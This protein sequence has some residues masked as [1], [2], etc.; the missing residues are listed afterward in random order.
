MP[1]LQ[2]VRDKLM[3]I[4]FLDADNC[5]MDARANLKTYVSPVILE[6]IRS[7]PDYR[8]FTLLTYRRAVD[9]PALYAR[10]ITFNQRAL[11]RCQATAQYS[12]QPLRDACKFHN[13]PE[14]EN[15]KNEYWCLNQLAKHIEEGTKVPNFGISTR[16]DLIAGREFHQSYREFTH[17]FEELLSHYE[18]TQIKT[19]SVGDLLAQEAKFENKHKTLRLSGEPTSKKKMKMIELTQMDFDIKGV[20]NLIAATSYQIDRKPDPKYITKARQ[21][22]Q[23]ITAL[24]QAHP[25]EPFTIDVIDDSMTVIMNTLY[26]LRNGCYSLLPSNVKINYYHSD[27]FDQSEPRLMGSVSTMPYANNSSALFWKPVPKQTNAVLDEIPDILPL[28][29]FR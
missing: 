18:K 13:E 23:T 17:R 15:I 22:I 4:L 29:S 8:Y 6:Y 3:R 14:I 11:N 26:D 2:P 9:Y 1:K 28:R 20:E 25:D 12:E 19:I 10:H 27:A 24:R 7:N 21:I 16:D 5:A